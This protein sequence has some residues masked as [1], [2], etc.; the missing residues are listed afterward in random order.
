[1]AVRQGRRQSGVW[2]QGGSE[3]EE[4]SEAVGSRWH[5]ATL[6]EDTLPYSMDFTI[7]SS[8]H[9]PCTRR[10]SSTISFN[11]ETSDT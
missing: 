10:L 8:N 11:M 6:G 9:T 2:W 1:M 3:V 7:I 5:I 4:E